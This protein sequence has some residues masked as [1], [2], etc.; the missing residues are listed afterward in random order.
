MK[1]GTPEIAVVSGKGGTGKTSLV[2]SFAALAEEA[3]LADCD[4]DASDLHLVL[5]PD[6][7]RTTPFRSGHV[8]RIRQSDCIQCGACLAH[9]RF[10]AVSM[11]G[12]G[13]GDATFAIDPVACEGC[14]VCV[15]F[16]PAKC[17]AFTEEICGEWYVSQTRFGPLVHAR[18]GVAAE[19]SGKLVSTVRRQ[20]REEALARATSFILVDG[21]PGI[22][23]PVIASV[24]GAAFVVV[25]TEPTLSGVHDLAR[26]LA[27]VK[28]FKVPCGVCVNKWDLNPEMA[29]R[30]EQLAANTGAAV[31][32]RIPYDTAVTSAQVRGKA[33]VEISDG[34]A[35]CA[36]NEVWHNLRA[37][38]ETRC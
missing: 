9:C 28:H 21:P 38:V 2:A 37:A 17:I 8:A 16:C 32:G 5:A 35:A 4:V 18:L 34:P 33:L 23:C 31:L 29:A 26:V 11:A 27:L 7:R 30:I 10:G 19:N 13:A 24:T 14:G 3:T 25:V 22:G 36:V 15:R 1:N 6:I 12:R 20:A